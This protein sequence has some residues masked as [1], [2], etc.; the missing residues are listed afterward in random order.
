MH[1]SE[2]VLSLSVCLTLY[3]PQHTHKYLFSIWYTNTFISLSLFLSR[4]LHNGIQTH[5]FLVNMR[6]YTRK[7]FCLS[8][9]LALYTPVHTH[10]DFWSIWVYI[11]GYISLL[12]PS[13]SL[14]TNL[15]THTFLYCRYR[16]THT[17]TYLSLSPHLNTH[18]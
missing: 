3:T 18:T 6:T 16:Y 5:I 2:C 14:S 8:I 12:S 7:H 15:N 9:S 13:F 17:Y 4:S 10:N 1:T 11:H